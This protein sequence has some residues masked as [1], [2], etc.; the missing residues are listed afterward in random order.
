MCPFSSQDQNILE[1]KIL[2][3]SIEERMKYIDKDISPECKDFIY[4]TLERNQAKRWT[5][6]Q[7]LKHKW[8]IKY[9]SKHIQT[10]LNHKQGI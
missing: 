4:R 10:K 8:I 6:K 1:D 2:N 3:D 5:C 7:L 9:H